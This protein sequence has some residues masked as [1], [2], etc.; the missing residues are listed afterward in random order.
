MRDLVLVHGFHGS[1]CA[2]EVI[3]GEVAALSEGCAVD[4]LVGQDAGVGAHLGCQKQAR[5]GNAGGFPCVGHQRCVLERTTHVEGRVTG[6]LSQAKRRPDGPKEPSSFEVA[7][8]N[9]HVER[10]ARPSRGEVAATSR[11]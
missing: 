9:R 10:L 7:V 6:L 5:L 1:P 8:E 11:G 4:V 2:P 3:V